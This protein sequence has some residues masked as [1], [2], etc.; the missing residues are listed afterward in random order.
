MCILSHKTYAMHTHT[1][2][3]TTAWCQLVDQSRQRRH[4]HS[5]SYIVTLFKLWD[6]HP[7]FRM[8]EDGN[9][10]PLHSLF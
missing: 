3:Y 2:V 4:G 6:L 9:S 5:Q 10:K 7:I 8:D 1:A